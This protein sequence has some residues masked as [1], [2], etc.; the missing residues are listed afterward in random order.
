M[1]KKR[2]IPVKTK[3]TFAFVVDG[4]C[5]VWYLQMLKRNEKSLTVTIEPQIPQKKSL[6]DQFELVKRLSIDYNQVFWIIDL[7]VIIRESIQKRKGNKSP[8]QILSEYEKELKQY[9]KVVLIKNNPCIEFWLL[10][11]FEFTTKTFDKCT[12]A[13]KQL[14]KHLADYEKTR[15]Y[16]TK[17]GNDIYLKLKNNLKIA[18]ANSERF[19]KLH[20]GDSSQSFSEMHLLF[21]NK[22]FSKIVG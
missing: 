14:K 15:N 9:P 2:A 11:H 8:L 5:E 12:D 4:E 19:I 22:E 17:S 1:R 6:F 13:E 20:S 3:P 18:K 10:L 21:D 7:D 16:Y